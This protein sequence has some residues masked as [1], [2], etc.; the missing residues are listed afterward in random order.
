MKEWNE[1]IQEEEERNMNICVFVVW[2]SSRKRKK[3]RKVRFGSHTSI[4]PLAIDRPFESVC[5]LVRHN[6]FL[7][8]E[9]VQSKTT[10]IGSSLFSVAHLIVQTF[11]S[12]LKC[13]LQDSTSRDKN[14]MLVFC[15]FWRIFPKT[16]NFSLLS[17][18]SS[19]RDSWSVSEMV[20]R[21]N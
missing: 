16:K 1:R 18:I 4:L 11:S 14:K 13:L 20:K 10:R 19:F 9:V 2:R 17:R 5:I 8:P 15:N 7:L 21:T 6:F 3:R 12:L